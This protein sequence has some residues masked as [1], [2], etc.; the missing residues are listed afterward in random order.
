ME[1]CHQLNAADANV[2][3][4]LKNLYYRLNLMEKYQAI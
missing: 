1:K 4:L 3:E 2:L